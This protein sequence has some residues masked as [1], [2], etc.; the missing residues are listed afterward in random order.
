MLNEVCY[1]NSCKS[2]LENTIT[3]ICE[4][5]LT[6]TVADVASVLGISKQNAYYLC[7]SKGFPC[8]QV[9]KR[10]VIP[11]PAFTKWMENPFVFEREGKLNG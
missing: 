8:I 9:G 5:P 11:K 4:L 7:H 6:L 1:D 10:L 3:D 2:N